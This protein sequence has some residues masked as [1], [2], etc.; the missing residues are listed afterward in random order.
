MAH[1]LPVYLSMGLELFVP[2]QA[3]LEGE[4]RQQDHDGEKWGIWLGLMPFPLSCCQTGRQCIATE[5]CA[6][7]PSVGSLGAGP[8]LQAVAQSV[9]EKNSRS[10]QTIELPWAGRSEVLYRCRR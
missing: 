7:G 6:P 8:S 2:G 5:V 3:S 10:P 4:S 1:S 9:S